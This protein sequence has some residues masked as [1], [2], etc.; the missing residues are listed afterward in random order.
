M[1]FFI[2]VSMGFYFRK[3]KKNIEKEFY[4][5]LRISISLFSP[6]R[7]FPLPFF[8]LFMLVKLSIRTH[9]FEISSF[10]SLDIDPLYMKIRFTFLLTSIYWTR[11]LCKT[12]KRNLEILLD[13][14]IFPGREENCFFYLNAIL[15]K[16]IWYSMGKDIIW[17]YSLI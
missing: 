8:S 10:Y 4:E 15:W 9:I 16:Y 5:S 2:S 13:A 6:T 7:F 14:E 11:F 17:K 1:I 12:N 3:D